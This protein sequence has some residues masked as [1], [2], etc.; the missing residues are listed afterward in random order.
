MKHVDTKTHLQNE[1]GSAL[2]ESSIALPVFLFIM[3]MG[4]ELLRMGAVALQLQHGVT[5]AA[6]FATLMQSEPGETREDSIRNRARRTSLLDIADDNLQF[7]LNGNA[8]QPNTAGAGGEWLRVQAE[9]PIR[10]VVG[11]QYTLRASALVRNEP[12]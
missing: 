4:I 9:R 1:R 7:C 3:F 5:A 12:A 11:I 8:C 6:R 10:L 2:V